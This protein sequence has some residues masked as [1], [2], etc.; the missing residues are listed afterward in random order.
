MSFKNVDT[1]GTNGS[2]AIGAMSSASSS[3]GAPTATLKS[4]R[5]NSLVVGVGN[6]FDNAIARVPGSNQTVFHQFLAPIGDTYWMQMQN[7]PTAVAGTSV[8]IN[9]IAPAGD[10]YN[11]SIVEVLPAAVVVPTYT[12]SG[13]ITPAGN[14]ASAVVALTGP[15]SNS[16]T[17][18]SSGNY[19]F[20]GLAN[21]TYT[22]TPSETGFTFTPTSQPVTVNNANVSAVNFSAAAQTWS[23]SGNVSV[24]GAGATVTLSGAASAST[25]AD[26]SG[27]YS[28]AGLANG[29]YTL[30]PAKSGFTFNPTSQNATVNNGNLLSLNFTATSSGST[31]LAIDANVSFDGTTAKTTISSPAFSTKAGNELIVAFI[32]TDYLSGANTTVSSVAGGGLNWALVKRTNVQSGAAEIWAAFASTALT[33]VTVT[34]T[35]SQS[36]V[37]SITAISFTGVDTTSG[38]GGPNAIGATGTGNSSKGAPTASLVTTR[39]NSWVLAVGNDY[40]NAINRTPGTGQTAV[41]QFLT[42]TGDTYWVQMQNSTTPL[43]GT[44][45][46]INDTAP[47]GDRYNLS[48]VEVR[49][50]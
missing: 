49:T 45:V 9:D 13:T 21:G 16:T 29:S 30:T 44:S 50:P 31:G 10:R 48:L 12:I 8:T 1:S 26:S 27:N 17:A 6:D 37:S 22:V 28:F 7:S 32:T 39:N 46:T 4:T 11:L 47:T 33:N 15:S 24:A 35:V 23:I 43:G 5:N 38:A 36:V 2:G 42:P 34:A 18:D 25:T 20:S 3:S 40:D 14:A 19:S 41:H